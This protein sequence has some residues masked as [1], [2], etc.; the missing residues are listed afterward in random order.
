MTE[1][2]PSYGDFTYDPDARTLRG[3]LL[4]FGEASRTAQTGQTGVVF[5]AADI[6]IPRDVSVVTLNREHNRH[7]PIG[8]ATV[9]EKRDVGVY[10]EFRLADTDEADDWLSRQKDTLRKLSAEVLFAADKIRAKITGSALVTDGAFATAGLFA[11]DPEAPMPTDAPPADLSHPE[12]VMDGLPEDITV[13]TP[14][15]A[16]A[17]YTPEDAPSEDNQEGEFAMASSIVP[18]GAVIPDPPTV[19]TSASALFAALARNGSTGD[20]GPLAPFKQM[21]ANTSGLFA[22]YAPLTDVTAT[23]AAASVQAQFVGEIY[24]RKTFNQRVIPLL[25]HDNLTA[26]KVDGWAWTTPPTVDAYAGDKAAVPSNTPVLAAQSAT[27]ERIAG[28]HD[29]DRALRDFGNEQ[30]WS[31]YFRAMSDSYAR[32]ADAK[33]YAK[34]VAGATTVTPGTVPA[35][36]D[37]GTVALVDGALAVI[38]AGYTPS[39]ALVSSAIFRTLLITP[40]D[41]VL[42]FLNSAIGLEEGSLA[43]FKIVPHASLTAKRVIVGAKEA[44]TVFELPGSPVRVEG[45][46]VAHGGIDPALYGYIAT[47]INDPKALASVTTV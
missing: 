46:D 18:D 3:M 19:D 44:A 40:K 30:F 2:L 20:A 16:Q 33:V 27:A 47:L 32:V 1:N 24:K 5:T 17:V 42:E 31:S 39:F 43:G 26:L 22:A 38:D 37:A 6:D 23:G 25:E 12:L 34:L 21:D 45:L 13:T 15:G 29:I 36:S 35:G 9:L 10:A 7:D 4:P 41:K 14:E 28:A 11:L 8:R